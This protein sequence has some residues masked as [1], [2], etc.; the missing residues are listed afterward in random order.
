MFRLNL[1]GLIMT[2]VCF[3]IGFLLNLIISPSG[4]QTGMAV[5]AGALMFLA[6]TV[7]RYRVSIGSGFW[8]RWLAP[9]NGGW[10]AFPVWIMG[11]LFVIYG[12]IEV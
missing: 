5:T 1:I 4:D 2:A 3:G 10:L 7:Y 9:Q 8:G 11:I 6:D 12:F